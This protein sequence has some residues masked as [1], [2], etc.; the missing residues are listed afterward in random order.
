[1]K[2]SAKT[3]GTHAA[4]ALLAAAITAG[5]F[6]LASD[7]GQTSPA[8]A[9]G[10]NDTQTKTIETAINSI[11]ETYTAGDTA[12]LQTMLC[13]FAAN[14]GLSMDEVKQGTDQAKTLGKLFFVPARVVANGDRAIAIG[15]PT[16][17]FEKVPADPV[18]VEMQ[19]QDSQW[20]LCSAV[21]IG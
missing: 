6:Y 15:Q 13:G 14:N 12:K 8:P 3:L 10:Q 19:K 17:E 1:M 16:R 18:V 2:P 4:T 11:L 5:G 9:T 20:K 21:P 7:H